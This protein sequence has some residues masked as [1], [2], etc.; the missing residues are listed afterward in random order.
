[1]PGPVTGP[2]FDELTNA[3]DARSIKGDERDEDDAASPKLPDIL[4]LQYL[5]LVNS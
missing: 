3:F 1:M 2:A 4:I 5:N